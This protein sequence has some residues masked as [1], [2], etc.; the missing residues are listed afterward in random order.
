MINSETPDGDETGN[1]T[2]PEGGLLGGWT[3]DEAHATNQVEVKGVGGQPVIVWITTNPED[4]IP[5]GAR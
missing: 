2:Q 1:D 3:T 5:M 4:A